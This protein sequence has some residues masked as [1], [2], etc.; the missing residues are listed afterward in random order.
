MLTA[1]TAPMLDGWRSE[2]PDVQRALLWL[3]SVLPD[4]RTDHEDLVDETLPEQHRRG[5][6]LEIADAVDSQEE[7]D[8]V[9]ALEDW[10][11]SGTDS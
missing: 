7:A 2:P 3:L 10:V 6:E 1:G 5:W 4:L 9:F 11:H 8:A